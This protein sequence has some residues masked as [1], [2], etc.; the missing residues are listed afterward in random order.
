MLGKKISQNAL[1]KELV[2]MKKG[3]DK[4]RRIDL[5][6]SEEFTGKEI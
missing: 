6:Q 3:T 2:R 4:S 1:G 5:I